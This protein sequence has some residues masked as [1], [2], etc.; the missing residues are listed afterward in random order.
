MLIS[1]AMAKKRLQIT[2]AINAVK[3][4]TG[5]SIVFYINFLLYTLSFVYIFQLVLFTNAIQMYYFPY[6][7][8][9]KQMM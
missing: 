1:C 5:T 9:T 8:I 2:V 7:L 3:H 4:K 6:H